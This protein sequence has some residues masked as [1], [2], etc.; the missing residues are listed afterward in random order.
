MKWFYI[1]LSLLFGGLAI[2][3]CFY[4]DWEMARYFVTLSI[5]AQILAKE[6][7]E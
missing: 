4:G 2:F 5:L 6:W 1:C 3:N 7:D